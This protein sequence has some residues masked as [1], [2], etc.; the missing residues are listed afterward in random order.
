MNIYVASSWRNPVQQMIVLQLRQWGHEVYDFRN[1]PRRTGFG[2]K[3]L[4]LGYA[5]GPVDRYQQ[6]EMTQH[7]TA[8]AGYESDKNAIIACNA[9]IGVLPFG[10]SASW[11]MGFAHGLGKPC[12]LWWEEHYE[13]E[14]M[15]REAEL[16]RGTIGLTALFGGNN[17]QD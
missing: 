13:P 1:P 7:A 11:E 14:L 10:K 16:I 8:K 4:G 15:F 2:W 17:C 9:C 6:R 12:F 3:Q 5:G